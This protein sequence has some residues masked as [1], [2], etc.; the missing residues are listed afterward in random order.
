MRVCVLGAKGF[1]GRNIVRDLN[2]QG[3]GRDDLDLMNVASVDSFFNSKSFDVVVHCAAIGGSRLKVDDTDVFFKNV[4]MFENVARHADKFK[5]LVWFSS[6]AAIHAPD[7]AYG[8]S[9][10]VCEKL[11]RLVPNCQVF[12]IFGCYGFDEPPTRFISSCIRG[13]THIEENR[14]FDFFWV[15]DIPKVITNCT[16]CDGKVRDLVYKTKWKLFDVAKMNNAKAISLSRDGGPAYIGEFDE[17][18]GNAIGIFDRH[19]VMRPQQEP[20]P[21]DII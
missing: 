6:G 7:S 15:G 1:I 12:R 3:Y 9:K 4:K 18:I 14:Y 10:V 16:V 19:P 5:R 21:H 13:P 11:A 8:F 20:V 2:A 17:E